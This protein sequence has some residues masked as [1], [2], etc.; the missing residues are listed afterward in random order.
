M[1]WGEPRSK[2]V[3][4]DLGSVCQRSRG[5]WAKLGGVPPASQNI[6]GGDYGMA[7]VSKKGGK[8]GN[9]KQR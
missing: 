4:S 6:T 7:K 5:N 9:S 2:R 3:A 1:R 8:K